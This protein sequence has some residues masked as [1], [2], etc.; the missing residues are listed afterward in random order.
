MHFLYFL[1]FFYDYFGNFR[2]G[3]YS[4]NFFYLSHCF[5]LITGRIKLQ[6]QSF[7]LFFESSKQHEKLFIANFIVGRR[8]PRAGRSLGRSGPCA[9]R[10]PAPVGP[11]SAPVGRWPRARRRAGGALAHAAGGGGSLKGQKPNPSQYT[12]STWE[13][14]LSQVVIETN[15]LFSCCINMEIG[16]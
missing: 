3:A 11:P 14:V 1:W 10:A 2:G 6:K 7:L 13:G 9:G 4:W 16:R 5:F 12:H 8:P 15:S